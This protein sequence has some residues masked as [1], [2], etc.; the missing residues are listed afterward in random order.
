MSDLTATNCGCGCGGEDRC[1]NNNSSCGCCRND[2]ANS[3]YRR[4]YAAG[5]NA[6]YE[7]GFRDGFWTGNNN[8]VM[9]I[10]APGTAADSGCGCGCR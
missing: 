4:G 1:G 10:S 9:P 3:N 8:N 6:G 2:W 7:T 5:F